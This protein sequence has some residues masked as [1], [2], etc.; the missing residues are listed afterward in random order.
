MLEGDWVDY[1]MVVV[2]VEVVSWVVG[3][4]GKRC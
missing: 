3:V 1:E 2:I 4:G